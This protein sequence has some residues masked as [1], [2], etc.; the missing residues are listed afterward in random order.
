[1]DLGLIYV[2]MILYNGNYPVVV[3]NWVFYV[4]GIIVITF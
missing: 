2:I 1:M 3:E 4:K